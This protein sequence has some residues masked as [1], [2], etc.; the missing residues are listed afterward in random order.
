[1][2]VFFT[3]CVVIKARQHVQFLEWASEALVKINLRLAMD[4]KIIPGNQQL[5]KQSNG[6]GIADNTL[7][8]FIEIEQD[9]HRNRP[10]DLF[11]LVETRHAL[12]IVRQVFALDVGVDEK[13]AA[14]AMH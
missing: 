7:R 8:R 12:R 14:Q 10:G 4:H 11:I 13:Q 2:P 5:Y 6:A 9:V 3:Q 1:M